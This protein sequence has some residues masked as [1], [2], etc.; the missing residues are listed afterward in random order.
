MRRPEITIIFFVILFFC[1]PLSWPDQERSN[2]AE[3]T[4]AN[5]RCAEEIIN[6]FMRD[7]LKFRLEYDFAGGFF[8]EAHRNDL[9]N[10]CRRTSA[11][12][13]NLYELHKNRQA[14]IEAYEGDGW[15]ELYGATGLWRK[16]AQEAEKGIWYKSQADFFLAVC[17]EQGERE[18]ILGDIIKRCQAGEGL[19]ATAGGQLLK[20]QANVAMGGSAYLQ[21]AGR[22]VDSILAR[23]DLSEDVYF[24]A[25]ISQL[26]LDKSINRLRVFEIVENLRQSKSKED[27]ELNMRLAFLGLRVGWSE[28]LEEVVERW[29]SA[30]DFIGSLLLEQMVREQ[31]EDAPGD[32]SVFEVELAVRGALE[33]DPD[34]Y[35]QLLTGFCSIEKYR[36]ALVLYGMARAFE[37]SE[38]EKAIGYY[39]QSAQIKQK[40]KD[41]SPRIDASEIIRQ[42][43]EI[44]CDLYYKDTKYIGLCEETLREYFEI[45][46]EKRDERLQYFYAGVLE[47]RGRKN[48]ASKLLSEIA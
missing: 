2:E 10:L 46:G 37:K 16:T 38:P 6:E 47:A 7:S 40:E 17:S 9:L 20:A 24:R 28:L 4:S 1:T 23:E 29:P 15:D 48:E 33:K 12:L 3:N 11:G 35:K 42:G 21:R 31:G 27:F 18:K 39:I 22:I 45:A 13:G 32:R 34:K 30:E 8:D 19:F 26:K 44:T 43:A 5:L 36:T 41:C 25:S 14:E